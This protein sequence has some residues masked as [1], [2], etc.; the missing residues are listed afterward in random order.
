MKLPEQM[1]DESQ[2]TS[3][4]FEPNRKKIHNVSTTSSESLRDPNHSV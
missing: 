1:F 2:I 3:I 4:N